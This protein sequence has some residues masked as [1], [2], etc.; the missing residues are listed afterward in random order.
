MDAL[1]TT[2]GPGPLGDALLKLRVSAALAPAG[3]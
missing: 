2:A 1:V 3:A